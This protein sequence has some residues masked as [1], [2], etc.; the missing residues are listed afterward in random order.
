MAIDLTARAREGGWELPEFWTVQADTSHDYDATPMDYDCYTPAQVA[1]WER[2]EWSFVVVSV[3]VEDEHGRMWGNSVLGGVESGWLPLTDEDD[4]VTG[5][6]YI[7][8]LGDTP[9]QYSVIRE[10][11]MIDE[12][13]RDAARE[14]EEFGTPVLR[15]PAGV[16]V[17]GL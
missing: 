11:D 6:T 15:E 4:T 10:H 12:A 8:P 7:D 16:T 5:Q 9:A 14:L 17:V 3:W 1:A 13:L 2:D